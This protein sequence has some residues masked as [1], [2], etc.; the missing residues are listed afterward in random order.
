MSGGY[1]ILYIM[2]SSYDPNVASYTTM[3]LFTQQSQFDIMYVWAPKSDPSLPSDFTAGDEMTIYPYTVTVPFIAPGYPLYYD[4]TTTKAIIGSSSLATNR[5]DLDKIRVVPNP[6]YGYNQNQT[7]TVDR[8]VTFRRLPK[9]CT[10][11][12]YSLNGDLIRILTKN[13]D[14]PTLRWN[15]RNLESVPVASGMYIALVDAEGIG[16]KIIKLAVFTPE[17]RLD[18]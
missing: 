10:I 11:K 17:E 7:S 4:F 18:F 14:D 16:Q 8:F 2:E 1:E 12:I 15:L 9:K 3:N 13:S 6:Y 5:G